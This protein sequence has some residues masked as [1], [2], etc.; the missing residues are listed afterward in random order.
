MEKK[1]A[2]KRTV[3]C[4]HCPFKK[5]SR[6]EDIPG[7][8]AEMHQGLA[9]TI[10]VEGQMT[11]GATLNI[12]ACHHSKPGHD[13]PCIG[14][15][16]NQLGPGNNIPLRLKMLSCRNAKDIKVVGEQVEVFQETFKSHE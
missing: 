12:M 11:I 3:Q 7:Y 4:R 1:W 14:W 6:L 10:A 9:A 15:L 2:L 5:S 16:Y 13:D 8:N